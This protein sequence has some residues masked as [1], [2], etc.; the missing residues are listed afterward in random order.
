MLGLGVDASG[1]NNEIELFKQL[2]S[3]YSGSK[4]IRPVADPS[5]AL[6]VKFGM[7]INDIEVDVSRGIM[8]VD[9]WKGFVSSFKRTREKNC[10]KMI[11][12]RSIIHSNYI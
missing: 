10:F 1:A 3:Q 9:A 2:Q 6:V 12:N 4:Y 5:E 7:I 8:S 11:S